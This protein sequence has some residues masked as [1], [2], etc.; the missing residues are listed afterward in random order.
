MLCQHRRQEQASFL[1]SRL[2]SIRRNNQVASFCTTQKTEVNFPTPLVSFTELVV[3]VCFLFHLHEG[4]RERMNRLSCNGSKKR[5]I[6]SFKM[7]WKLR[8]APSGTAEVTERYLRYHADSSIFSCPECTHANFNSSLSPTLQPAAR[9]CT[10]YN[11]MRAHCFTIVQQHQTT[12]T[13]KWY[14]QYTN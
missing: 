8:F 9:W 4:E 7:E 13:W 6:L 2:Q 10:H 5:S 11:V 14:K 1:W 12:T 3:P